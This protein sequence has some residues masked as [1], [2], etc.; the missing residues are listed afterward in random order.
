MVRC[1]RLQDCSSYQRNPVITYEDTKDHVNRS[2]RGGRSRLGFRRLQQEHAQQL[3]P[4]QL[5]PRLND[6]EHEYD[7]GH[8]SAG[9]Y[10]HEQRRHLDI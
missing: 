7:G 5:Q 10:G 4:L 1:R 6:G 2:R 9:E 8:N 3:R